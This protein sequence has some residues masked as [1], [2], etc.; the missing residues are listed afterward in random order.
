MKT[1]M[2]FAGCVALIQFSDILA[3]VV[4]PLI[5]YQGRLTDA[6]GEPL[7][8]ADYVLS[9]SVYGSSSGGDRIWGP[10]MFDGN[11]GRGHGPKIPVVQ[12]YFNVMLGPEDTNR[13]SIALAFAG[14]NR[15]VQIILGNN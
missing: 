12:G 5:N 15:W 10:Q 7:P 11:S 9:F 6:Q 1:P 4:P 14:S 3:Q 8:T 2:A 13:A